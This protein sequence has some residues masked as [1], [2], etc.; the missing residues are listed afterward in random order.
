MSHAACRLP[1]LVTAFAI[2]LALA[3]CGGDDEDELPGDA[4]DSLDTP[5]QVRAQLTF[6]VGQVPLPRAEPAF[7]PPPF[8]CTSGGTRADTQESI[9]SPFTNQP[10]AAGRVTFDDCLQYGGPAT[11]PESSFIRRH[12]VEEEGRLQQPNGTQITYRGEGADEATPLE[13]QIRSAL[14]NGVYEEDHF[15]WSRVHRS[16]RLAFFGLLRRSESRFAVRRELSIRYPDGARF[17][18][19]YRFGS[20]ASPFSI[21][22][23]NGMWKLAGEYAIETALCQ[24]GTLRVQTLQDLAYD[25]AQGRF[26]GGRLRFSADGATAEAEFNSDG[27]VR[28]TGALGEQLLEP[29]APSV[30]P[31]ESE[32][33]A[34]RDG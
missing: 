23:R 4:P 10:L 34:A 25:E 1:G 7:V 3:A 21:D 14:D 13:L 28:L 22:S 27:T 15:T 19:S 26:V 16:D 24:T 32:C 6:I 12:G 8:T 17:E 30:V 31:W 29:W 2:C 9:D 33:F 5:A 20:A 11:D 18:G